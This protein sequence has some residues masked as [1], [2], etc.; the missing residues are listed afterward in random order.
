MK[1]YKYIFLLLAKTRRLFKNKMGL[2][3]T[4]LMLS[5]FT[6]VFGATAAIVVKNLLHFTVSS[7]HN[8]FPGAEQNYLYLAFPLMGILLTIIFV[9]RVVRDNISHGVSIVLKSISKSNGKLRGHNIYSSIVASSLTVGFGGSVGLEAPMVLTGSAIGSNLSQLFNLNAKNR[10]LLLA[11]GCTAAI[12]AVFKAPV[13]AIVFAVEVL[14]IDFTAASIVPLLIAAATGTVLSLLFLGK[15][16]ML[17]ITSIIPFSTANVPFYIL[18]GLFT[19]VISIYFLKVSRI[20]EKKISKIK[21]KYIKGIIGS[22]LLGLLIFLFPVFY[23]EGYESIPY[24]VS[25]QTSL[26]FK[27]SPIFHYF[28]TFNSEFLFILYLL[29]IV[30]FK[31]FASSLTL[32]AGGIGGV[33]APS[34]FIGAFSGFFVVSFS[35]IVFGTSLPAANFVLA[36]MAGVMAGIMHTPVT[37][38]FLI[39]EMSSGYG[40]LIPLMITSSVSYLLVKPFEKHSIYSKKLA[41]QG[42]LKTHNK[43]KFAMHKLNWHKLIDSNILTIPEDSTLRVYTELIAKSKRNLF[44]VTDD[45]NH[46]VGMLCMDDHRE[47]IFKQEL[48]DEVKVHDLMFY[49]DT[50][51]LYNDSGETIIKKFKESG[52]FNLPVIDEDQKYIGFLSKA[53]TLTAYKDFIAED[54]ED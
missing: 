19:A 2:Q 16:V 31:V 39:A 29:L 49:P 46:F 7:L 44:V 47:I 34:L 43:D 9:S 45:Q 32:G 17:E 25:G 14:M 4:V 26:L 1:H 5:F 6:G 38:I 54:S 35:N 33:F 3:N 48:Y 20:V 36:G 41:E 13:A 30:L 18:L 23:G 21:S 11:C 10:T 50:V 52:H 42:E 37:S 8:A 53:H 40:L 27:N 51:A 28:N 22:I 12:A 15:N 24:L